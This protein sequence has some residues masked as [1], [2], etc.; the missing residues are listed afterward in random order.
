MAFRTRLIE[1]VAV[2]MHQIAVQL[3]KLDTSL[4]KNNGIASWVPPKDDTDFWA[5]FSKGPSPTLF[6]HEWYSD[7]DQYPDG[8]AD[9]VG[10]WAEAR[11]LG[12]VVLFD[13]RSLRVLTYNILQPPC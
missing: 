1:M 2:A 4:H 12:G 10:Y 7:Y 13:R 11:I 8:V 5:L 9:M 6:R 3:F